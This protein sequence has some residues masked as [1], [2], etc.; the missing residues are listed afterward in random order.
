M[1]PLPIATSYF[2]LTFDDLYLHFTM[3]IQEWFLTTV[4]RNTGA[5]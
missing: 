5:P 3:C 1:Y 2:A 4:P